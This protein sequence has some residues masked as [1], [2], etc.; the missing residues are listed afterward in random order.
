M[1][2]NPREIKEIGYDRVMIET[3]KYVVLGWHD[4]KKKNRVTVRRVHDRH[5]MAIDHPLRFHCETK[6]EY[7][8]DD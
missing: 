8:Y 5:V 2:P 6:V 7:N 1:R 4:K 3:R